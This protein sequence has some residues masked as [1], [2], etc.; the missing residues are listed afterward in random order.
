MMISP[1]WCGENR[2]RRLETHS[3]PRECGSKRLDEVSVGQRMT[4]GGRRSD[5]KAVCPKGCHSQGA[6]RPR[7]PNAPVAKIPASGFLASLGMT[8]L[9]SCLFISTAIP[10]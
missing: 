6:Q 1:L 9:V 4:V 2:N 10:P 5:G 8:A 3:L 7:N